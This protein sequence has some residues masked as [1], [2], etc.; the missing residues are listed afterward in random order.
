MIAETQEFCSTEFA[1]H[2]NWQD[3][4]FFNLVEPEILLLYLVR[5]NNEDVCLLNIKPYTLNREQ[6]RYT[7]MAKN[8]DASFQSEL[9][10]R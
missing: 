3:V 10:I 9:F 2:Y 6:S 8:N 4:G 7:M 5:C 1:S